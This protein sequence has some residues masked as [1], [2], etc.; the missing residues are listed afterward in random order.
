[1][2]TAR[3]RIPSPAIEQTSSSFSIAMS[4]L[5]RASDRV[6]NSVSIHSM[7]ESSAVTAAPGHWSSTETWVRGCVL[8]QNR[9]SGSFQITGI[10]GLK[11]LSTLTSVEI[12]WTSSIEPSYR[13][14]HRKVWPSLRT[15]PAKLRPASSR[16][17]W[18][19]LEKSVP[20]A[21]TR[22]TL[23]GLLGCSGMWNTD[24]SPA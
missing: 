1:M 19:S 10:S 2:S 20:T 5:R 21:L 9:T 17:L 18:A 23:G 13:P 6:S 24:D 15:T 3:E 11:S 14:D 16:M 7:K 12:V 8:A 22:P 4:T